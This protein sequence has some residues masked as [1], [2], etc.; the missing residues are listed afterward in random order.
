MK[1][2]IDEIRLNHYQ[3]KLR[4][5]KQYY[6]YTHHWLIDNTT[7]QIQD[8]EEGHRELF[9]I[10]HAIQLSIE[11]I[12]DLAA[13]LVKDSGNQPIDTYKNL[14]ILRENNIIKMN[15]MDT[16]YRLIG[17]RNRIAH[18]YNGLI[19]KIALDSY[20]ETYESI[21]DFINEVELWIKSISSKN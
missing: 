21:S 10:Y 1:I 16:L 5:L 8:N 12:I 20:T 4:H 17:L 9:S 15:S 2:E 13:M 7:F 3:E 18:D 6:Q 19:D 14:K 11:A